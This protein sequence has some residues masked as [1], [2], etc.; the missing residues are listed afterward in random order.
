MNWDGEFKAKPKKPAPKRGIKVHKIGATWWGQRW[1]E[2]LE[3]LSREYLNRL[4][5]GRA[6]ARAGRVFDLDVKA[7][8]VTAKVMGSDNDPYDVTLRIA[9][10]PPALWQKAI[11]GMSRQ[12][13]FGAELL[14][15]RMP[16]TID[17]AFRA[18]GHSLFLTKQRELETDCSCPDWANPCKHVAAVHYVLG[19]AFDHDPFLLFELRGRT[20]RQVLGALRSLRSASG[21]K[22]AGAKGAG[23]HADVLL[24]KL[25]T[26]A[27]ALSSQAELVDARALLD[28]YERLPAPLPALRFN[29]AAPAAQAAILRQLG[30]P[31]A[32]PQGDPNA[33]ALWERLTA[34]YRDAGQL[35]R[36]WALRRTETQD[37][38]E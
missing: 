4:G 36:D 37:A 6:Y 27:Q 28:G 19:E 32:W 9:M 13:M 2:A 18:A 3:H 10:L 25:A 35:A 24:E 1:L 34:A 5:R 15:G 12:A 29:V 17:E 26:A 30:S 38:S 23:K 16:A 21:L 33:D 7:G 22:A 14:A 11:A 31:P 20:K 8:L